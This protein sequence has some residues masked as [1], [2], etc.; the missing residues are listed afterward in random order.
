MKYDV[1]AVDPRANWREITEDRE[2]ENN[3]FYGMKAE[4]PKKKIISFLIVK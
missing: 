4:K 2:M 3:L 1:K